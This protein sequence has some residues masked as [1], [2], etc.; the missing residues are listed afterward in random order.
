[1]SKANVS[2]VA[3]V[4][5]FTI[6]GRTFADDAECIEYI[7]KETDKKQAINEDLRAMVPVFFSRLSRPLV[8]ATDPRVI[9][10]TLSGLMSACKA[11]KFS[12]YQIKQLSGWTDCDADT[13]ASIRF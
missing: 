10:A 6:N 7:G 1:M 9:R 3:K 11:R 8:G 12:E 5:G 2:T 4:S 13:L